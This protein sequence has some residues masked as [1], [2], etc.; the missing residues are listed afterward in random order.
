MTLRPDGY[1]NPKQVNWIPLGEHGWALA[2]L[3]QN[4]C[5]SQRRALWFLLIDVI[6]NVIVFIP[7]GFGLAGALHQ[8]NL[9]QTFRLAMWSGFGLSLLIELSQLAIPSRTTDVDDLIFNTLGAAIGALGFALL[10]RP[11]ASKLTKAA[12]DS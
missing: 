6:G 7:L 1:F 2:C 3:I 4:S 9:R 5:V 11:G 12:G 10:L 8:T